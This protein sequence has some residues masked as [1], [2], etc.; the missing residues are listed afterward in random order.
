M[1]LRKQQSE[2]RKRLM[3]FLSSLNEQVPRYVENVGRQIIFL[4]QATFVRETKPAILIKT[5]RRLLF[6]LACLNVE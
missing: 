6:T 1:D 3:K 2:V 5:N 4:C